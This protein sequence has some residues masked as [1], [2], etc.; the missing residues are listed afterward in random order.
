MDPTQQI[1][2]K[3]YLP[4]A[5]LL[6]VI[7]WGGLLFIILYTLPTIGP[8]WLFFFFVML[9]IVGMVM[10]LIAYLHLRFP[11]KP[12]I[13]TN[14]VV[15]Q[16]I[17]VGVYFSILAW[18]QIGRVLTLGLAL[19][20]GVGLIFLELL[21]RLRERSQWKPGQTPVDINEQPK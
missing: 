17:L 4:A 12:P 20:V 1:P 19:L 13:G 7:G 16:S 9:A 15:R 11:T 8:R 6:F 3:T 10:P 14:V 21:L 5:A 18:L 2:V